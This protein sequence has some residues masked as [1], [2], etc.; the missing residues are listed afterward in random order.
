MNNLRVAELSD[1]ITDVTSLIVEKKLKFG[2]FSCSQPSQHTVGMTF[3]ANLP[4]LI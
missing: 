4:F 1:A 3:M 2:N